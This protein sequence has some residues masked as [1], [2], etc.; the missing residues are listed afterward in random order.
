LKHCIKNCGQ[1]AADE[2]IVNIDNHIESRYCLISN[3]IIADL[4]RLTV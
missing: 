3:G 1:T 2:D 4:S